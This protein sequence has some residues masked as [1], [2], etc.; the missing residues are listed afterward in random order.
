MMM[1]WLLNWDISYIVRQTAILSLY[2][3][4]PLL[5]IAAV[6]RRRCL[7]AWCGCAY[8]ATFAMVL[9]VIVSS[10]LGFF[11]LTPPYTP[12]RIGPSLHSILDVLYVFILWLW[13]PSLTILGVLMI[14]IKARRKQ[15]AVPIAMLAI[16]ACFAVVGPI[17]TVF[18]FH[19]CG[20]THEDTVWA[21]GYSESGWRKLQTGMTRQ[22]AITLLGRPLKTEKTD[23]G[24]DV[25]MWSDFLYTGY[26]AKAVFKGGKAVSVDWPLQFNRHLD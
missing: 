25:L 26:R 6:G 19:K 13:I 14:V 17:W 15:T 22:Q 11:G 12:F 2:P 24:D 1:N 5:L 21:E 16:T 18:L 10:A 9:V 3:V 23:E 20:Y 8:I 7:L 4:V